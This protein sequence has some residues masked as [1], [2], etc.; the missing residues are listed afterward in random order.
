M[1]QNLSQPIEKSNLFFS[2][3]RYMIHGI[4][5][6]EVK[7]VKTDKIVRKSEVTWQRKQCRLPAT[8]DRRKKPLTVSSA[9]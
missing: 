2:K 1:F 3:S 9:T 8:A 6:E 4:A 5:L 7:T